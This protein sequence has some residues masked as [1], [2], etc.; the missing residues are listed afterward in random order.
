M[1]YLRCLLAAFLCIFMILGMV[2][3]GSSDKESAGDVADAVDGIAGSISEYGIL[4]VVLAVFFLIFIA[5]FALII[6]SNSK[7][8]NGILQ[9]KTHSNKFEEDM[10]NKLINYEMEKTKQQAKPQDENLLAEIDRLKKQVETLEREKG[11]DYHKDLVGAYIDINMAFKDASRMALKAL[12]CDR[13]A[14]YV[15]HN[16]NTSMLGLPFFKMSC[17]HEWNSRVTNTLRGKSHTEMPLHL[18]HDFIEDLWKT[19][20]Y[21]AENVDMSAKTDGSIAEFVA[22]SNV[23]SLY[24]EAIKNADEAIT[25]FVVAEFS[26][27]DTFESDET[28]NNEVHTV[29][30]KMINQI[31]PIIGYHYIYRSKKE[32]SPQITVVSDSEDNE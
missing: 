10:L 3:C 20:V 28:R 1:K 7:M 23:K 14:I 17:I 25:G 18:F 15:F 9:G 2:A 6:R 29:I 19:G 8:V 32:N 22:F 13:I 21:K 4:A 12:K 5:L 26:H 31:S 30:D 16:G 11:D 24:I 27:V